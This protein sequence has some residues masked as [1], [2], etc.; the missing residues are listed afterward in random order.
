MNK[1]G[2]LAL[3]LL[4][5][6]SACGGNENTT[7][8]IDSSSFSDKGEQV[9]LSEAIENTKDN[10]ELSVVS[11][12]GYAAPFSIVAN[13]FYYYAP[14][15]IGYAIVDSDK[16]YFHGFELN[17]DS[18]SLSSIDY[19][20]TMYGRY[21]RSDDQSI[22]TYNFM[23]ILKTYVDDFT[24]V[25]TNTYACTVSELGTK[26]RDFFQNRSY[27]YTN[28]FEVT[29]KGGRIDKLIPYEKSLEETYAY[30][31]LQFSTFI[32]EEY[33]PFAKWK[34]GGS[35]VNLR[36]F[37]LKQGYL[38][39]AFTWRLLYENEEVSISG[40][41][42]GFDYDGCFYIT[43]LDSSTG[44]LGI[45]VK[46]GNGTN[47]PLLGDIVEVTGTIKK[48]GYV[49]YLDN[50]TYSVLNHEDNYPYFDEEA[51]A[52][53]YGGGY[54][55]AYIFSQTP[56]YADSIYSTY[57][58]VESLPESVVESEDTIVNL[59]CPSQE[60]D[61]NAFRMELILP[62]EMSVSEREAS[63]KTLEEFNLYGQ[64]NAKEVYL[65]K[66]ILRFDEEYSYRIKLEFAKDSIISLSLSASEKIKAMFG[67]DIP[68]IETDQYACF[69]F[70]AATGY[71]LEPY[72]GLSSTS[73]TGIY[74]YDSSVSA[75]EW[76]SEITALNEAGFSIINEV[77]DIYDSRH[78]L[79]SNGDIIIDAL[80][81]SNASYGDE[82]E[83]GLYY[84]IYEGEVLSQ[85]SIKEVLKEKISYFNSEELITDGIYD[86][87]FTYYQ[88]PNYAGNIYTEGNYLNCVT[89][90]TNNGD[91]YLLE[92][93]R[94][95]MANEYSLYR[96][97]DNTMYRYTT[98][99]SQHYVLYK[100]IEGSNEKVYLDLALYSTD[101]YTYLGHD[102]FTNRIEIL[103]YKGEKPLATS[104]DDNLDYLCNRVKTN[105][106]VD[107][108][109]N[110]SGSISVENYYEVNNSSSFISYGYY[111]QYQLF[112]YTSTVTVTLN[113][114]KQSI[115]DSGYELSYTSSKGNYCYK[116]GDSYL[117]IMPKVEAGYIRIIDG[118]GGINF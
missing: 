53:S 103:I 78:I 45:R 26:L 13:D 81:Y 92:L 104:Y 83:Y 71:L 76:S 42:A 39:S 9:T 66:F 31:T 21:A 80:T 117:F 69:K 61:S 98:R 95:Y 15:G 44:N 90:D 17:A 14:N 24:K 47:S 2:L 8:S 57:A 52:N 116:N 48:E 16:D 28:Y 55:A 111:F 94:K 89:M 41:V 110:I 93:A 68:L 109:F 102:E 35:A 58:Y 50:A 77:K 18:D 70:G 118:V 59:I 37:D 105:Y 72:Y 19:I 63:I 73:T 56:V 65:E 4:L 60:E 29:V 114:I 23:D 32:K 97:E 6:L 5:L 27:A 87:Y 88:L 38:R 84:W 113:E 99:G 108:S 49:A 101:D 86:Y 106:K 79:F 34:E 33:A 54:Y 1:N 100:N 112:V 7:E 107:L 40:H 10:Y 96:N 91:G 11:D 82:D 75:S 43:C 46:P 36:I 67:I 3:A 85:P 30:T 74:Y 25:D 20:L 115:L 22:Y 51:I 12:T 64:T 62:K